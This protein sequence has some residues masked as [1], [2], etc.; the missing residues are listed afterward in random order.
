MILCFAPQGL[1]KTIQ[2]IVFLAYL[3]EQEENGPHLIVVP[4]STFGKVPTL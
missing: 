3:I 1:G 2:S 4:S